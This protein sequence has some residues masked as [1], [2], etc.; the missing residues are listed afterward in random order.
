MIPFVILQIQ[1]FRRM[2]SRALL[3]LRL[4]F[5]DIG[6]ESLLMMA[7]T[8][9]QMAHWCSIRAEL[10]EEK[11]IQLRFPGGI[12]EIDRGD[13]FKGLTSSNFARFN[14]RRSR[15]RQGTSR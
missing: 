11:E 9:A 4:A 15:N 2:L 5:V 8:L 6:R 3:W 7:R 12:P 14:Y 10:L 1:N 13:R